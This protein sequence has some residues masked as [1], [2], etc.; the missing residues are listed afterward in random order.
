MTIGF[1]FFA[2]IALAWRSV[3]NAKKILQREEVTNSFVFL[4]LELLLLGVYIGRYVFP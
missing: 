4:V 3:V 2:I 1:V